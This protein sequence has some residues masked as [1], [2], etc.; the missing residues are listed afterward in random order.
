M[1]TSV[2]WINAYLEPAASAQEQGDLLTA[3]GFPLEHA[4]DLPGGDAR[5]DYEMSSN[6]GDCGCH[7][8][9]AREIAA[10]SDRT[11]QVPQ[12]KLAEDGPAASDHMT[13]ANEDPQGCPRYTARVILGATVAASP[14]WLQ[15][16]IEARGDQS[17][18]CVVDATNFVLHE[19][20]Q[21]AHVF[22][23]DKIVDGTIIIRRAKDGEKFL[24]LGE[25]AEE[26]ELT[27]DDLVIADAE[28]PVALAGV[29]G[30][31]L[32]AVSE[33][34]TNLLIEAATFDPVSVR[35]TSRRH[36]ISSDSSWR[37]ERGV[38]ALQIDDCTDRLASLLLE[39]A[40][41]TLCSGRVEDGSALPELL[42]VSMRCDYCRQRLGMDIADADQKA[43]LARLGFDATLAKGTITA[44][45]PCFRGDIT[46]EID[47]VEEVGRV[48]GLE[49]VAV[50]ATVEV[51]APP[52]QAQVAGR[53]CLLDTLA[54]LG[55]VE[56][57][58]H[59][60]VA[61]ADAEPFLLDGEACEDVDHERAGGTPTVRPSLLP[62]LLR[63]RQAN[64]DAGVSSLRLA[65]IGSTSRTC[66][67]KHVE[68]QVLALLVDAPDEQ[69]HGTRALRGVI[70]RVIEAVAGLRSISVEDDASPPWMS[71]GG[72]VLVDGTPIGRMG[73]LSES[74]R[75]RWDLSTPV[76]AAE[77]DLAALL[78]NYP[79]IGQAR[80]LPVHPAIERD[81]S[82]IVEESVTWS[83]VQH[84]VDGLDL[85]ALESVAF[86][87]VFRGKSVADGHKSLTLRLRFRDAN[88][89]LTHEEVDGEVDLAIKA[90]SS[91]VGAEV[92]T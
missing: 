82:A 10:R 1:L 52:M 43:L 5:Q 29:K 14:Q 58:S 2:D 48:H 71:P 87:T 61:T 36:N 80:D 19:L 39:V 85:A 13:V 38:S 44:T 86:V 83:Q 45:V 4:E 32:T 66:G 92:R 30:G 24:P 74:L 49:H 42:K 62:S 75:A 57:I 9:L 37:F 90:L 26:I 68:T 73:R 41:G 56:C 16:R 20:G 78:E 18:G 88:R 25:G 11:L 50:N 54:G 21:P 22:D 28:K 60:L 72:T 84:A 81:I 89:T 91:A 63:I 79:P 8:G 46:R 7:V 70:D 69:Q 40:G 59:T 31:A 67:G 12:T 55:F 76:H 33:S 51:I 35:N 6:R 65:E 47:L 23:L 64:A 17:R 53:R 3:A 77:L 27:S 15:D 34:T